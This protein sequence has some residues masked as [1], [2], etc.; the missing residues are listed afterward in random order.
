[1][2]LEDLDGAST[3][4]HMHETKSDSAPAQPK[5]HEEYQYLNLIRLILFDGEHRPDR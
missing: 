5:A 2:V 4:S 1:M 3:A